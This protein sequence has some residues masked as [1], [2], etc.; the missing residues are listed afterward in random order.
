MLKKDNRL[1]SKFEYNVT[2]KHGTYYEGDTF[3]M[4]ALKPTNYEGPSKVGIV[5]SNKFD[6]R[7]TKRNKLKRTYRETI[8]K[9]FDGLPDN[10]WIVVQPK[11]FAKE[12]TYEEVS[13]DVTKT[14][15]KISI[16]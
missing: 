2:R 11:F 13:A 3:H 10:L 9:V 5:I 15:Q 14:L 12:K 8:R 16:S 4:Y 1:T 6:K 7:A